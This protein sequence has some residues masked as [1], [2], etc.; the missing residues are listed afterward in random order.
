MEGEEE[1]SGANS[2]MRYIALELMKLAQKSGKTFRQVAKEYMGNT[3]YLQ[4]LISSE[5]E[6][7]P[8]RGRAGQYSREK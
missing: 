2:E 3:C 7:R 8:R 5:A 4:K 1:D 6:A